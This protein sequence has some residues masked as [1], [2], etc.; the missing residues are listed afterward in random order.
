VEH[1]AEAADRQL[2]LDMHRVDARTKIWIQI[3]K[4]GMWLGIAFLGYKSVAALAG[5]TTNA[6]LLFKIIANINVS[7]AI[8]W[9]ATAGAIVYGRVQKNLRQR[10]V[11]RLATRNAELEKR[12]DP[13][14]TSS[15]LTPRGLTRPGD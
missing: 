15:G 9:T 4:S 5:Q 11:E 8:S 7:Y 10:A 1:S 14:R 13:H 12:L 3:I 2:A 6:D